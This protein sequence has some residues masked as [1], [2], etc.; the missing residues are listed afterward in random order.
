[1]DEVSTKRKENFLLL[2]KMLAMTNVLCDPDGYMN[3]RLHGLA[4]KQEL[5]KAQMAQAQAAAPPQGPSKPKQPTPEAEG[6]KG[7]QNPAHPPVHAP[8][9]AA[10][11]GI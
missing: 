10:A 7:A 2:H 6:N 4:H 1:M 3:V 8:A 9:P 5:M 11:S